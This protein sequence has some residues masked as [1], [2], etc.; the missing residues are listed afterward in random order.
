[1]HHP[2]EKKLKHISFVLIFMFCLMYFCWLGQFVRATDDHGE[3]VSPGDADDFSIG[4]GLKGMAVV[5]TCWFLWERFR[6]RMVNLRAM[7]RDVFMEWWWETR[8]IALLISPLYCWGPP[9]SDGKIYYISFVDAVLYL[10][11]FSF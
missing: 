9:L 2:M 11:L 3:F 6:P 4:D 1:M 10:I 8:P 7:D 5:L